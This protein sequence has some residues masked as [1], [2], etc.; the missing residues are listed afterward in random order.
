M[1]GGIQ[2][3]SKIDHIGIAVSNLDEAV[4]LY[5]DVL[6][7]ELHGTEVVPEQKVKVAFLPVGD[8]EVE[9]LESTS[10]EGPIAKFIEAKGQGIQHIAFRVDDIEAAL[11]EMKAKGMRLI[12]EK[13]RYGAGGAKIAFLHPKSTGGVLIELCERK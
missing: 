2:L 7:L 1:K 9:L 3:V 4:K 8:T 5:R 11:E 6:G 13:P 10:A 12:D